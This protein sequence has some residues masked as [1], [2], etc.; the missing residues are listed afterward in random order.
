MTTLQHW[1]DAY[2]PGNTVPGLLW[3]V[4]I[5]SLGLGLH[6]LLAWGISRWFYRLLEAEIGGIHI[7]E[8][9]RLMRPPIDALLVL[10]LFFV[11]CTQVVIPATGPG[12]PATGLGPL[13]I[14]VRACETVW[15][16]VFTWLGVRAVRVLGLVLAKRAELTADKFDDQWVPFLR[17]LLI[18]GVVLAGFFLTL[19]LVFQVNVLALIASLGLGGLAVALAAR[20]TLENLFASVTLLLDGPFVVGDSIRVG[21]LEGDVERIGIR[22]TRLRHDDGNLLVVPNRLLVSQTLENLTQRRVRRAQFLLHL[23][24][25]TP[26]DVLLAFLSD[27]R[28]LLANHPLTATEPGLVRL[29]AI[30]ERAQE[31]RIIF[32]IATPLLRVFRAGKEE[33]NLELLRLVHQHGIR[34][35]ANVPGLII[36]Q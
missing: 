19:G 31:V 3:F 27:C 28:Q 30:G 17:D 8:F 33:I 11:A 10:T 21:S 16:G 2:L 34:F 1:L 36:G 24:L 20:E 35:A 29:D 4:G 6:R 22:S 7:S 15:M 14:V 5:L 18:V 23:D 9:L 26:P 25:N 13:L 32:F 12:Q